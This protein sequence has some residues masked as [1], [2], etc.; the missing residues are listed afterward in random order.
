MILVERHHRTMSS[1]IEQLEFGHE[2]LGKALKE[3]RLYVDVNQRS[4]AWEAEHVKD[5]FSDF[6]NVIS[7]GEH[8]EHFLGSI[9]ATSDSNGKP[10]IVD[11][12]QRLATTAMFLAAIRD[13]FYS[14]GDTE[15]ATAFNA[16]Y[17]VSTD[18]HTMELLPHLNLNGFDNDYFRK[19]VLLLPDDPERKSVLP[20]HPSNELIDAAATLAAKQVKSIVQ[21]NPASG[22][23]RLM[24]WVAFL[25]A[26][27]K[28]IWVSV[29]D[30]NTAYV[31]FETMNDR[32]LRLSAADLLKNYLLAQSGDRVAEVQ[33][34]WFGMVGVLEA[35]GDTRELLVTYIRHLWI[36]R[37]EH[38]KEKDLYD[39]I[40]KN[41]NSKQKSIDLAASL[42]GEAKTYS[43]II[44]P[45]DDHWNPYRPEV[46]KSVELLTDLLGVEQLRPL[47]LSV[48][49]SFS[50]DEIN[51]AL[52]AIVNWSVRFLVSGGLG[53]GVVEMRYAKA[54]QE[55]RR[56]VITTTAGLAEAL[57]EVIPADSNFYAD[58]AKARVSKNAIAR[59]YLRV[60]EQ[61][62]RGEKEPQFIPNDDP[63]EINLEHVMTLNWTN[64]P[65]DVVRAHYR[66]LGNMVLLQAT[67]NSTIGNSPFAQ[68]QPTLIGSEFVLT[69]AVG[70][71]PDWNSALIGQRQDRLAGLAL[72]AWPILP[73]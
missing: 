59:Y 32:G 34:H 12:Q 70:Q 65:E 6:E 45:G 16:Q 24:G 10:K 31:I 37:E 14:I 17:L 54:A 64:E 43:A 61:Q 42:F 58:F 63:N 50:K 49:N 28:V 26:R 30:D 48:A 53:S 29:P 27:A 13:H 25:D 56:G 18:L 7:Q 1:K 51:S 55:I 52:P 36:S 73:R 33:Q 62:E 3:R 41:T 67:S 20:Q 2:S 38:T 5:L 4:Y 44:N 47:L 69:R 8:A 72:K 15:R 66:R 21:V 19:R 35:V 11:G 46:R 23:Q 68:K 39:T 60:L 22:T 57:R 9:I 40:K 71:L